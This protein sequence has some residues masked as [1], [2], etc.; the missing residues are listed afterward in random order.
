MGWACGSQSPCQPLCSTLGCEDPCLDAR[1]R[2]WGKASGSPT[3]CDARTGLPGDGGP[4]RPVRPGCPGT[5]RG[6]V[7]GT[8]RAGSVLRR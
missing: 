1:E 6:R 2:G 4:A 5:G 8:P 7:C 3:L